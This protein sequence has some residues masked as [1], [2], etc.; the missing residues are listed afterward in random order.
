MIIWGYKTYV[1]FVALFV[2]MCASCGRRAP[3]EVFHHNRR[4]S[5]F[6]IPLFSIWTKYSRRCPACGSE[7]D[8]KLGEGREIRRLAKEGH[9]TIDDSILGATF[10]GQV[11]G[12]ELG[13]TQAQQQYGQAPQR[14]GQQGQQPGQWGTNSR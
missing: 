11:A 3:Q 9:Q 10:N 13:Y 14:Y 1:K 12:V 5:L 4:F 8:M 6:F 7:Y 2:T